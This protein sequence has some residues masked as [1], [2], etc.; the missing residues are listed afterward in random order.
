MVEQPSCQATYARVKHMRA[1]RY[2][3]RPWLD[4]NP[5]PNQAE[6]PRVHRALVFVGVGDQHR[7]IVVVLSV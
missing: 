3:L 2:C 7:G 6:R 4:P 1:G 5:N